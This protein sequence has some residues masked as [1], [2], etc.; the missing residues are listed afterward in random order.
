MSMQ[1]PSPVKL[2]WEKEKKRKEKGAATLKKPKD[3]P[4]DT[5]KKSFQQLLSL[6][7]LL[8]CLY[9]SLSRLHTLAKDRRVQIFPSVLLKSPHFHQILLPITAYSPWPPG[10]PPQ[11]NCILWVAENSF[12][13]NSIRTKLAAHASKAL[14]GLRCRELPFERERSI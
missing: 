10:S 9:L 5:G 1:I 7:L 6:S 13:H 8:S 11:L 4:L 3:R 2:A 12:S 14:K